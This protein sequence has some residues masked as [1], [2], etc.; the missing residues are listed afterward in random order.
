[1][2]LIDR[3]TVLEELDRLY[4]SQTMSKHLNRRDLENVRFG[5]DLAHYEVSTLPSVD[6]E[7]VRH[8]KWENFNDSFSHNSLYICSD[9][10]FTVDVFEKQWFNYC[11]H[12]G[13]KMDGD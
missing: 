11:P 1:M 12:C 3:K 9:C 10:K 13:A 6:A 5:I 8:G 4:N 7:P 2:Y